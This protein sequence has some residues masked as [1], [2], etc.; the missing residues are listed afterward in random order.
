MKK[1]LF[2]LLVAPLLISCNKDDD[3]TTNPNDTEAQLSFQFE[4]DENQVRLNNIGGVAEIPQGNAAQTPNFKQLSLHFIELSPDKWTP[5]KDGYEAY[6][7][8]E[9][10]AGG[11]NAIDFENAIV[12]EAGQLF[13]SIPL[14]D[15]TPGTYEYIRASVAYQNYDVTYNL[16]NV[17]LVG[18]VDNQNGTIASFLGFNTYI[19]S[20]SPRSMSLEVNDDKRQGFWA[21]ETDLSTPFESYNQLLSGEAPEGATTVVNPIAGFSEIP[22]GS[23]VITGRFDS[24][25][26]ITGE[27]TEDI[28]VTLS[29]S[30]NNS[31]EWVDVNGNGEL[32]FDMETPTNSDQIVDMGLRGL[33][34]SWE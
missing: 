29:F 6:K 33:I 26:V 5:Y 27:E 16:K 9:T 20:I 17:P 22:V 4:F 19:K 14:K 15:V 18:D 24:P 32:D 30:I 31:F 3:D 1:I 21:F 12:A 34:G 23:C 7:G 11:D 25:L 13:K 10:M 8:A 2:F 28:D